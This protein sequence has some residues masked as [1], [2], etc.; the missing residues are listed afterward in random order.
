MIITHGF[1]KKTDRI[2]EGEI[3]RAERIMQDFLQRSKGG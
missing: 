3:E 1:L 2:P